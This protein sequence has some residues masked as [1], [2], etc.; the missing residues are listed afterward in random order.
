VPAE[1]KD[2]AA[3]PIKHGHKAVGVTAVQLLTKSPQTMYKGVLLRAD[4]S[5]TVIV[6]VGGGSNVTADNAESTGGMPLPAGATILVPTEDATNIWL[7]AAAAAQD[8]AW[9]GA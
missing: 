7:I 6:Y 1:V 8:I 5:N 9:I 3:S 2:T 4:D